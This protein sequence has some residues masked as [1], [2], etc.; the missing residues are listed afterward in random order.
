LR[1]DRADRAADNAR[2]CDYA[3]PEL[4][5]ARA[6]QSRLSGWPGRGLANTRA[7]ESAGADQLVF[8]VGMATREQDLETIRLMGE[9]VIPKI[10]T[11]PVHRT[12]RFRDA[13]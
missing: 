12:T 13:L 2:S 6:A 7:W 4:A 10:D 8:G 9:H 11:D 3:P 1:G 5:Q